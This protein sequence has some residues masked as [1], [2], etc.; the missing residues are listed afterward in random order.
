MNVGTDILKDD[1]NRLLDYLEERLVE[2]AIE[3]HVK[4]KQFSSAV[5]ACAAAVSTV[6]VELN[7]S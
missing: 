5:Y 3:N 6:R 4:V 7:I 1:F 2:M